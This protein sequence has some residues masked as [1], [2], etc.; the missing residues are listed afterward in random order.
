MIMGALGRLQHCC[1]IGKTGALGR[2][3][4]LGRQGALVVLGLFLSVDLMGSEMDFM[5]MVEGDG[6]SDGSC[7]GVVI[8]LHSIDGLDFSVESATVSLLDE[9]IACQ[10][11][12]LDG[13]GENDELF[14]LSAL[15]KDDSKTYDVVLSSERALASYPSLVYCDLMLNDKI[16]NYPTITSIEAPGETNIYDD[17]YHHGV[18]FESELTGYRIYFDH[19]QNIDIYG[20]RHK[21]LELSETHF[22][23]TASQQSSGYGND[24][25]WA[26]QSIGCGS[27]KL[28]NGK[29]ATNW[30]NV[31][32]R[33]QRL[34]SCGPLRTIVEVFDLKARIDSQDAPY[35]VRTLYTQYGCH[36][37]IRVD[38]YL[39]RPVKEP[40]LCTG[41]QRIGSSP[42]AL[43]T[44]GGVKSEGYSSES[45]IAVSWGSDYPEM[46][47]KDQFP[48]EEIGLSVH[49][50][51]EYVVESVSDSLNHLLVI[52]RPGQQHLHYHLSFSAS[53][54]DFGYHNS[55]DWFSRA[56][57]WHPQAISVTIVSPKN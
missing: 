44:N 51:Q 57:S 40:F 14:F 41:V 28:W 2:L 49:V 48:P 22:Y 56:E 10:L 15:G 52:G 46:G 55:Q 7:S 26:G 33:S 27:L 32:R 8:D 30:V 38:I 17:L 54:E 13:D 11:D 6:Y 53:K 37:D 3:G 16:G 25:L 31:L 21:G 36:R 19:R 18:E 29:E 34:I 42:E 12:D 45:G 1:S 20:K 50:P 35:N 43:A 24:V 23:T 4:A 9:E 5:V 39:D 47:K